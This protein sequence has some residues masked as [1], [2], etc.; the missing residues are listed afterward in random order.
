[1][2]EILV[3]FATLLIIVMIPLKFIFADQLKKADHSTAELLGISDSILALVSGLVSIVCI[4]A[5]TIARIRRR[6]KH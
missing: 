4:L 6:T 5:I 3:V 1:M 2:I